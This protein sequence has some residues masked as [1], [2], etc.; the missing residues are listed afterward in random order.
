MK[1]IASKNFIGFNKKSKKFNLSARR[2]MSFKE[3]FMY[4]IG[5]LN[6]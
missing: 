5:E 3:T 4:V 2:C 1:K 6:N